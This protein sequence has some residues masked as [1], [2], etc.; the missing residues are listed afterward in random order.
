MPEMDRL[1]SMIGLAYKAGKLK[2]GSESVTEAVRSKYKPALVLTASDSS[3]GSL[4]KIRD[5][6]SYH[7]VRLIELNR[8][9]K[10]LGHMVGNR[11]SLM[12]VA[13]LDNGFAD[14]IAELYSKDNIS[15]AGG[16]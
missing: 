12:C 9:M 13:I 10:A 8:D 7:K 15:S 14:R 6:C 3:E 11:S 2:F 5:A 1:L 16:N 4:K